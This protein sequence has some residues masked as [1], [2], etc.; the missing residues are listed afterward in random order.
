METHSCSVLQLRQRSSEAVL[1]VGHLVIGF[2]QLFLERCGVAHL[3]H[4]LQDRAEALQGGPDLCRVIQHRLQ[5]KT[6]DKL[7][8]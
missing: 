3:R 7:C 6:D 1:H 8:Q 5:H 4:F 2:D